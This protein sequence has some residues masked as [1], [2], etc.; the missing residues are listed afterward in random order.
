MKKL[1]YIFCVISYVAFSQINSIELKVLGITCPL[2]SRG[3][4]KRL[5]YV[6]GILFKNVEIKSGRVIVDIVK[7]EKCVNLKAIKTNVELAGFTLEKIHISAVGNIITRNNNSYFKV[8]KC[9]MEFLVEKTIVKD[10]KYNLK[11]A[12][13]KK[14]ILKGD[15]KFFGVDEMKVSIKKLS[16]IKSRNN[17]EKRDAK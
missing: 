15:V 7:G 2:C 3:L 9:D 16:F 14:V 13:K 5:K 11:K 1:I 12:S 4:E 6:D 8:S 17:K 10:K